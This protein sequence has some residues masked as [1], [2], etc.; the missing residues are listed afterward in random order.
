VEQQDP[1]PE[2]LS[3]P[4]GCLPADPTYTSSKAPTVLG[5]FRWQVGGQADFGTGLDALITGGQCNG[6]MV[7]VIWGHLALP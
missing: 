5:Q 7:V 6:E 2:A 1:I 4:R 3:V